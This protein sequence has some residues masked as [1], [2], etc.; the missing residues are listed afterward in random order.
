MA[1]E[2]QRLGVTG[3]VRNRSDGSVEALVAGHDPLLDAIVEWAQRGPP[4][5]RVVGVEVAETAGEFF[6]FEQLPT[7]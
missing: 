7:V 3:W 4:G 2:A 5:A 6:T 1:C